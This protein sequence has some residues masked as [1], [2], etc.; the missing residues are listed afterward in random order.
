M[1]SGGPAP[2]PL[3]ELGLPPTAWENVRL[4]AGDVLFEPGDEGDAFFVVEAGTVEAY[5][6]D[7]HGRRVVLERLGPGASFGEL[8]LLDGGPRTAGIAAVGDAELRMLR[9]GTFDAALRGSPAL[10][11]R[12]LRLTGGRLRRNLRH[13]DHLLSWAE[14]VADGRYEEA[15]AAIAA[16]ASTAISDDTV[17]FIR[18]FEAMLASVRERER[19][20]VRELAALRVEIDEARRARSVA[21]ITESE[22][23][24]GL[25]ETARRLRASDGGDAAPP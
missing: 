17:R 10:A 22:F 8:A 2:S 14:L 20:L 7:E 15:Q 19:E 3:L 11:A 18:S 9:R 21:E 4:A 23:F 12:L 24:K 5:L 13:I 6:A 1:P 25:Q 16:A